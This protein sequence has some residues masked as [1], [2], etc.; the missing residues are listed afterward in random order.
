MKIVMISRIE[1]FRPDP[2]GDDEQVI[3]GDPTVDGTPAFYYDNCS[4][5]SNHPGESLETRR[6]HAFHKR[7]DQQWQAI[8]AK[9]AVYTMTQ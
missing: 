1:P 9:L 5:I 8:T 6:R 7:L 2:R 3:E 4:E